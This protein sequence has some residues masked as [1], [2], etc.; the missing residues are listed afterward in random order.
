VCHWGKLGWSQKPFPSGFMVLKSCFT[1]KNWRARVRSQITVWFCGLFLPLSASLLTTPLSKF[2][3][4]KFW[5][6]WGES[7]SNSSDT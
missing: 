3:I 5:V 7:S 6:L 4:N 1:A 2:C